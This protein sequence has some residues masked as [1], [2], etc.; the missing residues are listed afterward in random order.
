MMKQFAALFL[1]FFVV[2]VAHSARDEQRMLD[3]AG[4]KE[5]TLSQLVPKLKNYRV[6]LVGEH[7]TDLEHHAAQLR[8]IQALKNAGL[9]VVIGLEM[10]RSDSQEA[11]DRWVAGEI[12]S[13]AFEEIYYD[14][15]SFSWP[16][17]APIFYY[18]RE[19]RIPMIGLNTSPE[20]TRQVAKQ[21]FA[22]LTDEQRGKLS[23][24]TCRVDEEYMNFIRN[25][26]GAHG[27]GSI[28]DFVYF[29]EAQ[30]VWDTIMAVNTIEYLKKNPDSVVVILTGTG[31][32]RKGAIPRQIRERSDYSTV[33]LLPNVAGSIDTDT[34]DQSDADYLLLGLE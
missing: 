29:C 22:S 19:R 11:L 23:D 13:E 34:V 20:I 4:R 15:W 1:A 5:T 24:V 27:H 30:M 21:G 28:S 33:V 3:L 26:F 16:A 25:A 14:N 8:V 31:H 6:I 12:S 18:A 17:Y 9:N 10:F 7:H 2:G 32:A